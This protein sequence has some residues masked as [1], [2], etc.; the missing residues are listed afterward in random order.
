MAGSDPERLRVGVHPGGQSLF[1]LWRAVREGRAPEI[2]GVEWRELVSGQDVT[3]A[4]LAGEIDFANAGSQSLYEALARGVDLRV[5]L[6]SAPRPSFGALV[7]RRDSEIRDFSQLRGRRIGVRFGSWHVHFLAVV[8]ARWGLRLGEVEL[9]ERG[10]LADAWMLS[11]AALIAARRDPESGIRLILNGLD[12]LARRGLWRGNRSL[13]MAEATALLTK[14]RAAAALIGRLQAN[15]AL[16]ERDPAAAAL[17]LSR[18]HPGVAGESQWRQL[19]LSI[20]WTF[21]PPDPELVAELAHGGQILAAQGLLPRSPDLF[22]SCL[23]VTAQGP[24]AALFNPEF[25]SKTEPSR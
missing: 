18:A 8:L 22:R 15:R 21:G 17:A 20:P 25:R 23:P 7:T 13:A 14:P 11:E 16:I 10:E 12:D 2:A 24:N 1:L 5:L 3:D 6:S 9:V 19:V 4:F